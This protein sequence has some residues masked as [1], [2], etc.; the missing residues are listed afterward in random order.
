MQN[1]RIDIEKNRAIL[2]ELLLRYLP[3]N[4]K[5][6]TPIEGFALHRYDGTDTARPHFYDP[7]LIVAVQGRKWVRVGTENFS[8]GEHNC[9]ITGVNMP[10]SSCLVEAS[11]E[12]PY[13]SVALHLNKD[14]LATLSTKVPLSAGE[15]VHS[16]V[17]AAVQELNPELLDA[18]I[19]LLELLEKPEQAPILGA[20]ICE[21]IHY[22]L[23]ASPFGYHLRRLNT[24]GFQSNQ[25]NLAVA[26]LKENYKEPLHV[27]QLA[28]RVNMAP[29][30][31]HK[32][33]KEI[34]T[35]S[36]LQYQKHLR[37]GE[38]QRLML[39]DNY[40][41]TQ[42]TFAVGYESTTQFNREYKRLYG[43][44]PRRDIIKMKAKNAQESV[45]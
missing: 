1:Y 28:E 26:W 29:S 41:V 19:R 4:G 16:G 5:T 15:R 44:P 11:A 18:F 33:F 35:L 14:L 17:G 20:L 42:A 39:T 36:P 9:F 10:V 32:H 2:R 6:P 30:T 25:I 31:F 21:E 45:A 13:L 23:L 8:F 22:R 12:K 7:I 24:L 3:T 40:D 43:E 37:L 34:T 27:D 38:A